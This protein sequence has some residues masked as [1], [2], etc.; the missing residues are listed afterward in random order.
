MIAAA[1]NQKYF[2]SVI[3]KTFIFNPAPFTGIQKWRD[4]V[5]NGN[6]PNLTTPPKMSFTSDK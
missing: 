6:V 3:K 2:S 1:R 5:S 4:K